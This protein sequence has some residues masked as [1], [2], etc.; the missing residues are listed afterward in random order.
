MARSAT[1][2]AMPVIFTT[3]EEFISGYRVMS[4]HLS[5]RQARSAVSQPQHGANHNGGA[6]LGRRLTA[7]ARA[8]KQ[9]Q[10]NPDLP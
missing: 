7:E 9:R 10:A 4:P 2:K 3:M 8:M 6:T 5:P 1:A